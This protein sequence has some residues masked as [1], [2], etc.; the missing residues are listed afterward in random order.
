MTE[1][2]CVC[3]CLGPGPDVPHLLPRVR[4]RLREH[5]LLHRPRAHL[6]YHALALALSL[7]LSLSLPRFFLILSSFLAPRSYSCLPLLPPL[8]LLIS[9]QQ[10][11]QQQHTHTQPHAREERKLSMMWGAGG[12]VHV[13]HAAG[14]VAGEHRAALPDQLAAGVGRQRPRRHPRRSRR[15]RRLPSLPVVPRRSATHPAASRSR[16]VCLCVLETGPWSGG[17][18][19]L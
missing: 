1:R 9:Q 8:L 19:N 16:C 15:P 13:L 2:E 17:H 14:G 11:Q 7:S 3:P 18:V 5:H 12:A 6:S 4:L 10:Q